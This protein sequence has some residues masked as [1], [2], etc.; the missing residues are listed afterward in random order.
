MIVHE[1]QTPLEFQTPKGL[2][3]AHFLVHYGMEHNI[4]WVITLYET[5]EIWEYQNPLVKMTKNI[6]MGRLVSVAPS[7]V[8]KGK[9]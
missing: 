3:L 9:A 2:G 1:L 7:I 5:G 6:T 8:I 4:H